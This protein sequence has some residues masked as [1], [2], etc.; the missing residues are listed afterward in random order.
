M[1]QSCFVLH[2]SCSALLLLQQH[3]ISFSKEKIHILRCPRSLPP[4][5]MAK[6][7]ISPGFH[8]LLKK[9]LHDDD[10][11]QH[12][13]DDL[14]STKL[15]LFHLRS[16]LLK[17]AS[18]SLPGVP[19]V[20]IQ[21]TLSK[22]TTLLTAPACTL[23]LAVV[24]VAVSA[25]CCWIWCQRTAMDKFNS[26]LKKDFVSGS[27]FSSKKGPDECDAFLSLCYNLYFQAKTAFLG[28]YKGGRPKIF[29]SSTQNPQ[30]HLAH[31]SES[32]GQSFQAKGQDRP[33]NRQSASKYASC[34]SSERGRITIWMSSSFQ[35]PSM[36]WV[37]VQ[38][39][40]VLCWK[41]AAN[42]P[43]VAGY[44][45]GVHPFFL[46]ICCIFQKRKSFHG[47]GHPCIFTPG[48]SHLCLLLL[49][50][51][52]SPRGSSK[53]TSLASRNLPILSTKTFWEHI[54]TPY[55]N[56]KKQI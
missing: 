22:A 56:I 26:P 44:Y 9:L 32:L 45:S 8:C 36:S 43:Q 17:L 52:S 28:T 40:T 7:S 6:S 5:S 20:D 25:L 3:L 49:L 34:G 10:S 18:L 15:I 46:W 14:F 11:A 50:P 37:Y 54:C 30:A 51:P 38:E 27:P 41:A 53:T 24:N 33:S 31:G 4:T 19:K 35:S 48:F 47:W 29:A 39:T 55:I 42:H 23:Q 1:G 13:A 16:W 21:R 2:A 12:T